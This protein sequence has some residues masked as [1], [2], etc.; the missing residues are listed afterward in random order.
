MYSLQN[1][2]NDIFI[3]SMQDVTIYHSSSCDER[4][5]NKPDTSGNYVAVVQ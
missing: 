3:C 4:V 2:D 5:K 1:I